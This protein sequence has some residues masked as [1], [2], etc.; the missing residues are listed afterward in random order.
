MER[1]CEEIPDIPGKEAINSTERT[2]IVQWHLRIKSIQLPEEDRL[3]RTQQQGKKNWKSQKKNQNIKDK[4][5]E[6]TGGRPVESIQLDSPQ[7]HSLG[8]E[9]I[10]RKKGKREKRIKSPKKFKKTGNVGGRPT[11]PYL[12]VKQDHFRRSMMKQYWRFQSGCRNIRVSKDLQDSLQR[13]P[14][15]IHSDKH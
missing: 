1:D 6:S 15:S 11:N 3:I 5:T 13:I 12:C 9:L 2:G 8:W 10:R 7:E 4:K 14:T